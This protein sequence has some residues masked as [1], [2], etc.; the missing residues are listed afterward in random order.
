MAWKPFLGRDSAGLS[1]IKWDKW[2]SVGQTVRAQGVTAALSAGPT[3]G[4]LSADARPLIQPAVT[5][6]LSRC[7][8][9]F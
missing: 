3:D 9:R 6:S 4:N 8:A 2:D 1:G 7:M 5:H